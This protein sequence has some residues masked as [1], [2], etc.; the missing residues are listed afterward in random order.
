MGLSSHPAKG[1]SLGIGEDVEMKIQLIRI[2]RLFNRV[3]IL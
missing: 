3:N 2:Y 1:G